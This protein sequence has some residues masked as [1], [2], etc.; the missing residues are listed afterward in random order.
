MPI[1]WL[2]FKRQGT[3]P[4]RRSTSPPPGQSQ[5]P[6]STSTGVTTSARSSRVSSIVIQTRGT[7]QVTAWLNGQTD[8]AI[9]ALRDEQQR[10]VQ[11]KRKIPP[12]QGTQAVLRW[13]DSPSPNALNEVLRARDK[14]RSDTLSRR[15]TTLRP[16]P[17]TLPMLAFQPLGDMIADAGLGFDDNVEPNDP[18][19][20]CP[21]TQLGASLKP[22]SA[23]KRP[24]KETRPSPKEAPP[25]PKSRLY[26]IPKMYREPIRDFSDKEDDD[27]DADILPLA[28]GLPSRAREIEIPL[29]SSATSHQ[30]T[31]VGRTRNVDDHE[32]EEAQTLPIRAGRMMRSRMVDIETRTVSLNVPEMDITDES[33][34]RAP[35][36][37]TIH[38]EAEE[39]GSSTD[40]K[41]EMLPEAEEEEEEEQELEEDTDTDL[42]YEAVPKD[43]GDGSDADLKDKTVPEVEEPEPAPVYQSRWSPD[44]SDDEQQEDEEEEEEHGSTTCGVSIDITPPTPPSAPSPPPT[45]RSMEQEDDDD[46]DDEEGFHACLDA[47]SHMLT[48]HSS[49]TPPLRQQQT[50]AAAVQSTSSA[51][52]D[53]RPPQDNRYLTVPHRSSRRPRASEEWQISVIDDDNEDD[54][55]DEYYYDE[56]G[57]CRPDSPRA[58]PH[59][60][61]LKTALSLPESTPFERLR[62][63]LASNAS[64][65]RYLV[66]NL[67][68]SPALPP[69]IIPRSD[70]IEPSELRASE[71]S[72]DL[73][74]GALQALLSIRWP[75]DGVGQHLPRVLEDVRT[76]QDLQRRLPPW[77]IL[78]R[79]DIMDAM[80]LDHLRKLLPAGLR[81]E[82]RMS[83]AH[84]ARLARVM[85]LAE[86]GQC[87]DTDHVICAGKAEQFV[88]LVETGGITRQQLLTPGAV[89]AV[90][91][92]RRGKERTQETVRRRRL[93]G[94]G[95]TPLRSLM[96]DDEN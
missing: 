85:P 39:E 94:N 79:P 33:R 59:L 58:A 52:S 9:V 82:K 38:E 21:E 37:S 1:P 7:E 56:E 67:I 6:S 24:E 18:K 5:T 68:P 75:S 12:T 69:H 22:K 16:P 78:L 50:T 45:N 35:A 51:P 92:I 19:K 61:L 76:V 53:E 90:L 73:Y 72:R 77:E 60:T 15:P 4:T 87:P 91:G 83:Y 30:Q 71:T 43:E 34:P 32:E 8:D 23:G 13:K 88:R 70:A 81:A 27:D 95:P 29:R 47:W 80:A 48:N 89:R 55:D 63:L 74:A 26:I 10:A 36:G 2:R 66:L 54:S 57:T 46:D 65:A 42:E 62:T 25:R 20:T 96:Y 17:P 40:F 11:E 64:I 84:V 28:S 86:V 93:E 49:V 41:Y 31:Q 3:K 44:S 14:A